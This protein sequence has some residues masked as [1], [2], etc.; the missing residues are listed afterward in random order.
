MKT[1]AYA[2]S[3]GTFLSEIE[4]FKTKGFLT[5]RIYHKKIPGCGATT[6]ELKYLRNS[7]IIEPNVPVIMGKCKK[8]NKGKRKHKVIMGVYDQYDVADIKSYLEDRKGFKKI[9]T[10]P[11]GFI[12]VKEAIGESIYQD[13]FLLFDECEKAIQDVDFRKGIIDP[14]DEFFKFDNKAFISATPI[15]PSDPRFKEFKMVYIEPGLRLS[16]DD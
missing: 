7:I 10:T 4:P 9:L 2:L 3:K 14:I 8:M 6:L 1:E 13:Y 12:K 5:D 11:E 16:G 15:I